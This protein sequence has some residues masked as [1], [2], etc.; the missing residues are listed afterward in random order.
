MEKCIRARAF[1]SETTDE[2]LAWAEGFA[3]GFEAHLGELFPE[4]S[5]TRCESGHSPAMSRLKE[6]GIFAE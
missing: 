1:C 4:A 5:K 2:V 3:E 6:S